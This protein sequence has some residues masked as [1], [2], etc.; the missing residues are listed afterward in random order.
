[1]CEQVPPAERKKQIIITAGT[2]VVCVG[3]VV[4]YASSLKDKITIV[5]T[6]DD[7]SG[8]KNCLYTHCNHFFTS[9]AL[10]SSFRSSLPFKQ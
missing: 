4:Q 8:C 7:W 9:R 6:R 5:K 3:P 10:F 2:Q 1:M